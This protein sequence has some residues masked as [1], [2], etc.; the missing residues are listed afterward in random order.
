[1]KKIA[2]ALTVVFG[3]AL[4]QPVASAANESIV[5]I[6]TA[7]DST[8]PE[9]KDKLIYEACF[10]SSG[11]KC[12]N[13]TIAQEG[14]GSATLPAA[15]A[16]EADFRHG[17]LMTLIANQINPNVNIIFIRVA[18]VNPRTG[19]AVA[20]SD[21]QVRVALEWVIANKTKFNIVSVSASLGTHST[22]KKGPAYCPITALKKPLVAAIDT[23]ITLGVPTIFASGNNGD[24][25]RVDFPACIPSA[26]A[27][28]ATDYNVDD[29]DFISMQSNSAVETDFYA[30]GTYNVLGSNVRG[31]SASAVA[32]SAYWAKNYKGTYQATYDYLKSITKPVKNTK[33]SSTLFV[34]ILK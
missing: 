25:V 34:D 24:T 10:V 19:K 9:F 5:I 18:G 30:L 14:V 15:K 28:S 26:V 2:L 13:G 3:L 33:I 4:I 16:M 1:M 32:F 29:K 6:D 8:R 17:T 11:G 7:I 27:V 23:L 12:P 22:L 20:F 21:D 31:T